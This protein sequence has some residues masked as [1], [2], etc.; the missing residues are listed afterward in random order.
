MLVTV[1][2]NPISNIWNAPNGD[3]AQAKQITS[4]KAEGG[5]GLAWTPD[6]R[7]VYTSLDSGNAQ[8]WIMKDDGSSQKQITQGPGN[9]FNPAVSPDGRY[10]VFQTGRGKLPSL[11]RV[12]MD[13]GNPKQLTKS[14]DQRP[15]ISP[16]SQWII[17]DSWFSEKRSLWKV[18]IDG[19]QPVQ[20]TDKLTGDGSVSPDGKLIACFYKDEQPSA[21]W[22]IM[23]LSFDG[24]PPVM[25]FDT[26]SASGPSNPNAAIAWTPNG[27]GIE[28]IDSLGGTAN[29]WSQSLGG[30]PP[31]KLTAFKENGV[32]RFAWSRDG[33]QLALT[34]TTTTSDVVLIR[35][36][37]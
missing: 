29:L 27:R 8:I 17:F 19:G 15:H 14:D 16:D 34:R 30:G 32:T 6:G 35:D 31:K 2:W 18:S 1:Q 12:D 13:G 9:A 36:F 25:T 20:L 7:I 37:R 23:I 5:D 11:W 22:R 4:G 33:K 21:Q 24:G 28:Y 10:I 26:P 3:G